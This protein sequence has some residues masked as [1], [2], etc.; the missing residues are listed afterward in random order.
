MITTLSA[1]CHAF[2]FTVQPNKRIYRRP[3]AAF[4]SLAKIAGPAPVIL[5]VRSMQ[6]KHMA[7]ECNVN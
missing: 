1:S 6:G 2:V 5:D 7:K 3:D 4:F